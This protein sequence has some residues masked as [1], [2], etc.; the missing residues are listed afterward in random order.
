MTA[1]KLSKQ[2]KRL[3]I[4]RSCVNIP[5]PDMRHEKHARW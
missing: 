2:P 3:L 4:V 5:G 1:N